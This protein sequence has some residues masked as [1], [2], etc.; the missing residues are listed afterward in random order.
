M[1]KIIKNMLVVCVIFLGAYICS[2][3]LSSRI[4]KL[5]QNDYKSNNHK[6]II[7]K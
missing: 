1:K 3:L 7:I 6:S 5:E 4:E 2:I